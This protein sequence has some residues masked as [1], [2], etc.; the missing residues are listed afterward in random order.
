MIIDD[1]GC[2]GDAVPDVIILQQFRELWQKARDFRVHGVGGP[3]G[4]KSETSSAQAFII[5]IRP[6]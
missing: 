3:E 6:H 2:S 4:L 1:H 5:L